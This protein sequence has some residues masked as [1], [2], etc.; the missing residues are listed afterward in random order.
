VSAYQPVCH[1]IAVRDVARRSVGRGA[2]DASP[3]G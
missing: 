1:R 3:A 2:G